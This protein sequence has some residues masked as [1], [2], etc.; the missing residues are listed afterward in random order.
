[1]SEKEANEA[2][3]PGCAKC[4]VYKGSVSWITRPGMSRM[5]EN[6]QKTN[7]FAVPGTTEEQNRKDSGECCPLF[8]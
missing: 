7:G 2:L 3:F 4:H 8:L 1:M 5:Q 6:Q